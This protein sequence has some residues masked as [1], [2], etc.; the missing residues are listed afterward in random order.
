MAIKF[1]FC[2]KKSVFENILKNK[3][4]C[5]ILVTFKLNKPYDGEESR[6]GNEKKYQFL[7]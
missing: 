6:C 3:K 1:P 2:D 5:R 4:F 7:E